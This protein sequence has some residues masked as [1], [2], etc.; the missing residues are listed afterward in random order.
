MVSQAA[1]IRPSEES[2]LAGDPL[3]R[4]LAADGRSELRFR[5]SL[6]LTVAFYVALGVRGLA[7]S[8]GLGNFADSVFRVVNRPQHTEFDI[9]PPPPP[10]P[11]EP[12]PEKPPEPE[13]PKE[14]PPPKAAPAP[15]TPPPAAQAA[16]VLTQ[17]PDPDEPVDLTGDGFVQGTGD[18]YAGGVTTT[19]GT[20]KSAVRDVRATGSAEAAPAAK[21]AQGP[22]G[23]DLSRKAALLGGNSW[24]RCGFPAEADIEQINSAR[25]TLVVTV[26]SDGHATSAS[27]TQDPG[28][29]FGALAKRCAL[30]ERYAP[31]LNKAGEPV[32]ATQ[33]I[34]INFRR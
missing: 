20:S 26:D 19:S 14:A 1:S 25:V 17:D 21:T 24:D 12:E 4:M 29:G 16:K 33:T 7:M 34:I 6:A 2:S 8:T 5:V 32:T 11:P 22:G 13:P 28:Y 9:E 31:A 3:G 10:P 27:V 15:A 30:R 18:T 23:P